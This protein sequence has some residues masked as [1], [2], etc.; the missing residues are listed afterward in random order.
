MPEKKAEKPWTKRDE[1]AARLYEAQI[2][3]MLANGRG[4]DS[5]GRPEAAAAYKYADSFLR[6]RDQA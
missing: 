1:L 6:A 4:I 3:G 2:T 5:E